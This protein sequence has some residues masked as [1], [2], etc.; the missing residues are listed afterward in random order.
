MEKWITT[1]NLRKA[2][3]RARNDEVLSGQ[4]DWGLPPEGNLWGL[5]CFIPPTA[6]PSVHRSVHC[7]KANLYS[8]GSS[9]MQ[10]LRS[11]LGERAKLPLSGAQGLGQAAPR[12]VWVGGAQ[13]LGRR[14]ALSDRGLKAHRPLEPAPIYSP[15][16]IPPFSCAPP[17]PVS[18]WTLLETPW[19]EVL[20]HNSFVY[21]F[22]PR[23]WH[24]V[25]LVVG[26]QETL[27]N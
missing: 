25:W 27:L 2:G 7:G 14:G 21:G 9:W 17:S 18:I 15:L 12:Q 16:Q 20:L 22:I 23:A 19:V 4:W 6:W 13:R 10:T 3:T 5:Q 8:S 26:T 24:N 11:Q 1:I